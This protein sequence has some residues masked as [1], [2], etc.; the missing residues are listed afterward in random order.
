VSDACVRA[1]ADV[2]RVEAEWGR[3][4]D[5]ERLLAAAQQGL[6]AMIVVHG[7]TST[8]VCQPLD[9]LGQACRERDALLLVDCVTSLAGQRLGIDE[10]GVDAAF[11]GTQKCLNCPPGLAPFTAGERAVARL[12]ARRERPRSWYW[13]LSLV[14]G[15]WDAGDGARVYHH[16]APINMV[17]ALCE[18]L[19]LVAEE[20]LESRW[21]RHARAH[22]ALRS[23]LGTLGFERLAPD[24]EQLH[25]LLAVRVPD[26][27]DEAAVRRALLLEHG[28]E[29]AGGLGPFAGA[30]WRIGVMGVGAEH[31]PQRRLVEAV[32]AELGRD[33]AEPLA[34]LAG[35][36]A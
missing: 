28:I 4:I 11:S 5:P 33:A 34:A 3:A 32:C 36:W 10:A 19:E 8:G 13:D 29:V 17:Y 20:G 35:G 26:G 23:A 7:E 15:Y 27:I 25:P 9:G 14:L 30:I 6:D 12:H 1:G 18:A 16:T 22:E 21:A 24:G 2:A 31:E